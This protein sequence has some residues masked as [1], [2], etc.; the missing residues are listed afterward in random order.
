MGS[1]APF[2]WV[3]FATETSSRILSA[4]SCSNN[5]MKLQEVLEG[6]VNL[7]VTSSDGARTARVR[8]SPWGPRAAVGAPGS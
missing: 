8:P 4:S 3:E 5:Q 7:P 1:D 6:V 2:F